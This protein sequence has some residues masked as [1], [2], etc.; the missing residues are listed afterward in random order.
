MTPASDGNPDD[1]L[2]TQLLWAFC[3]I[4]SGFF[5]HFQNPHLNFT[6]VWWQVG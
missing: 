2:R 5:G 1:E 4:S 6:S 3:S